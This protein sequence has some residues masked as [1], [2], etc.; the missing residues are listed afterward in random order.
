[1]AVLFKIR[2]DNAA[3]AKQAALAGAE[4]EVAEAE[5]KQ[6][7]KLRLSR[8]SRLSGLRN[9]RQLIACG[10]R[11]LQAQARE[12]RLACSCRQDRESKAIQERASSKDQCRL[13]LGTC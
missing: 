4:R 9:R 5:V 11:R 13:L 3:V 6:R 8:L 7:L 1:V 10:C 12:E 2:H